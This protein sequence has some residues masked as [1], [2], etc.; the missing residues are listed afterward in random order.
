MYVVEVEERNGLRKVMVR[1][2]NYDRAIDVFDAEKRR[3][4]ADVRLY[5]VVADGWVPLK[6]IKSPGISLE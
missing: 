6:F 5:K 3:K 4:Y 1:S 2:S